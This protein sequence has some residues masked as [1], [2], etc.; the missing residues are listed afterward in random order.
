MLVCCG[1]LGV[2][3]RAVAKPQAKKNL[4][5]AFIRH[6]QVPVARSTDTS[7]SGREREHEECGTSRDHAVSGS[8]GT[9]AEDDAHAIGPTALRGA[10]ASFG[11]F[12]LHVTA[13]L[14]EK[15]GVPQKI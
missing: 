1:R 14:L 9:K 12:R 10:I 6:R 2:A 7:D 8:P 4:P 13:R 5:G 3:V 11:P 15:A